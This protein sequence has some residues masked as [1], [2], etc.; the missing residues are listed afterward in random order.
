[1]GLGCVYYLMPLL[2]TQPCGCPTRVL[3]DLIDVCTLWVSSFITVHSFL[4]LV[5]FLNMQ[6]QAHISHNTHSFCGIYV[7][8]VSNY[9]YISTKSSCQ[10]SFSNQTT[11]LPSCHTSLL[12]SFTV[13]ILLSAFLTYCITCGRGRR[14]C[15]K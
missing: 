5:C 7:L 13:L 11:S 10:W 8:L 15:R 14:P 3:C 12:F 2:I 1:M 4:L 9:I 6:T